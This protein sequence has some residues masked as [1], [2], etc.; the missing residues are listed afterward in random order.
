MCWCLNTRPTPPRVEPFKS[1]MREMRRIDSPVL[2]DTR[3]IKEIKHAIWEHEL[4]KARVIGDI[5]NQKK[6]LYLL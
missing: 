2:P 4:V 1:P 6:L 3:S 5:G